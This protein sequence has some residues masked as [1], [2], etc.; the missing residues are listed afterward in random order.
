[1]KHVPLYVNYK[2]IPDLIWAKVHCEL[3][4][5]TF[6]ADTELEQLHKLMLEISRATRY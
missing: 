4:Y 2:S 3:R 5:I 6:H 1:M